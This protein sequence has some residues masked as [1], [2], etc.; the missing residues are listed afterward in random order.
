MVSAALYARTL[1]SFQAAY[2]LTERGMLADA[3]TVVDAVAETA[4]VCASGDAA[5]TSIGALNRHIRADA[6]GNIL[7]LKFGPDVGDLPATL[8]DGI[9]A[10]NP[11]YF[12]V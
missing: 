7:G 8:S 6:Q 5:H 3:R 12:M 1:T 10:S 4:I 11:G 2:V 9:R